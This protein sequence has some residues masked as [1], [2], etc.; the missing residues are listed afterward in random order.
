[1]S[2]KQAKKRRRDSKYKFELA[3]RRWLLCKPIWFRFIALY[4]W[5]KAEPKMEDYI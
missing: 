1:M 3:H 2:S 4:R 5:K